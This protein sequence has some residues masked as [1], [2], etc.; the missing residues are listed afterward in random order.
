MSSPLSN[1]SSKLVFVS[2]ERP[3]IFER[4]LEY[5]KRLMQQGEIKPGD[6][7]LPERDLASQLGVSRTS[8]REALRAMELLGLLEIIPKQGASI[9]TPNPGS[10]LSFLG[11]ALSL[12]P[13]ISED[14]LEVRIIIECGAARLATKRASR[15]ELA[16]MK[17]ILDRMPRTITGDDCGAQADFDFHD[18]IIRA[19]HSDFLMFVYEAIEGLLRRSHRERRIALF[20]YPRI[21]QNLVKDHV[22]IYEAVAGGDEQAAEEKMREH[23]I[24]AQKYFRA[25]ERSRIEPSGSV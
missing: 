4:I 13:I 22:A 11:L 24:S 7:L 21:L 1:L 9:L 8:L 3:R 17:A 18:S 25:V 23:F 12:R 16:Q 5:F 2:S 10:M 19:T 6:R 15:E 20:N 14:I